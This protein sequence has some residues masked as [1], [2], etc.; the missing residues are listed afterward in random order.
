M[1][2]YIIC[3]LLLWVWE[4]YK[5]IIM[6][7]AVFCN[8]LFFLNCLFLVLVYD[9]A[10][11]FSLVYTTSLCE[12]ATMYFLFYCQWILCL[13]TDFFFFFANMNNA[14]KDIFVQVYWCTYARIPKEISRI[15]TARLLGI[16]TFSLKDNANFNV[17]IPLY[18]LTSR[19][20]LS[21][22]STFSTIFSIVC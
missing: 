4:F 18:I 20:K 9:F 16:W 10:H 3:H 8:L 1:I 5:N 2:S 11:F 14:S 15:E 19:Y 17:T 21:P 12:Y 7:Y 6:L 22:W 13:F